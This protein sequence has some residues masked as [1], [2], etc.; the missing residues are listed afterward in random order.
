MQISLDDKLTSKLSFITRVENSFEIYI[1]EEIDW[2]L[3][4]VFARIFKRCSYLLIKMLGKMFS[5]F[6]RETNKN[7]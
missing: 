6:P 5:F 1:C 4:M 7:R 3:L 2:R